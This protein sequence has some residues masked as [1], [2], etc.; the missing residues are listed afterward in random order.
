MLCTLIFMS[1]TRPDYYMSAATVIKKKRKPDREN[2]SDKIVTYSVAKGLFLVKYV[3]IILN[4][5]YH[6]CVDRAKL[7][8]LLNKL[9]CSGWREKNI[10]S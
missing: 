7:P 2:T 9:L 8:F 3:E 6:H 5:I 1:V 10:F 4:V